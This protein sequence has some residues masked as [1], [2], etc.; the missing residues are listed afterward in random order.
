M[1]KE[2]IVK[3][4]KRTA[5]ENGGV[6]LGMDKFYEVTGIKKTEWYGKFWTKWSDAIKE[7]GYEPNKFSSPAYEFELLIC[8]IIEHTRQL[9]HFPTRPEFK[10]KSHHDKS[11]PSLTTLVARLGSKREMALKVI[12]YCKSHSG[13]DDV[14]AICSLVSNDS[15]LDRDYES[16]KEL[17]EDGCVYL[18]KVGK[19]YKIGKSN[20]FGRRDY[21][22][23]IQLPEKGQHIHIITTDD[24]TGI[25]AY[26][27]KR[28]DKKRKN[29][30]WF[31]LDFQDVKAFKRRK[32]M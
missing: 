23:N 30:E 26:W 28:F 25:E 32:F 29:G 27:H 31:E 4:I 19:F 11:F 3:A 21:E 8:K 16:T 20:H 10:I 14:I 7:A 15:T 9:G 18:F 2:H 12:E 6:A 24:P 22:L 13:Y 5:H 1:D 17:P